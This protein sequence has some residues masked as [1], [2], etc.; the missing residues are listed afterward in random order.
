MLNAFLLHNGCLAQIP[1]DELPERLGEALWIDLVDP[2]SEERSLVESL[3]KHTL[4]TTDEVEEIEASARAFVTATGVH[5]RSYFLA[6]VD[7]KSLNI[8]VVFS[9]S[10]TRLFTLR[11]RDTPVFRLFRLRARRDVGLVDG[12]ASIMTALLKLDDLADRLEDIY[13]GLERVAGQVLQHRRTD[14]EPAI[15]E[16]ARREHA[17]R[18]VRLCLMDSQRTVNFLLRRYRLNDA[19]AERSREILRDIES[20]LLQSTFLFEKVN[21][22][23]DA[24]QGFIGIQQN[25][26]IKIFFRDGRDISAAHADRQQLRHELRIHARTVVAPWIPAR[27]GA[28]GGLGGG[29]L[30]VFQAQGVAVEGWRPRRNKVVL[31]QSTRRRNSMKQRKSLYPTISNYL[32]ADRHEQ[33]T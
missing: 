8:T 11:E 12:A 3:F 6:E 32:E 1:P 16:L 13:A 23:M 26:I 21:F 24:A 17:N 33:Q 20:L 31:I 18:T 14:L 30:L 4:P 7:G 5:V 9:L 29:A 28:D 15:D 10:E 19:L 22:L 2:S 27:I 25:Q